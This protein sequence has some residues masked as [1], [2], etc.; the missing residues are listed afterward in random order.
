MFDLVYDVRAASEGLAAMLGHRPDF[1]RTVADGEKSQS[2][3]AVRSHEAELLHRFAQNALALALGELEVSAVLELDHEPS[4]VVV[5]NQSL[6]GNQ[7][8][9][10][11]RRETWEAGRQWFHGE[12]K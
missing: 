11:G 10:A 9:G 5:P 2:M 6:E 7:G 12:L 1:D 4:L 3:D 8:P